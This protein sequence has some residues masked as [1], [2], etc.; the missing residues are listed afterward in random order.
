MQNFDFE[1]EFLSGRSLLLR[2]RSERFFA[3]GSCIQKEE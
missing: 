1:Q 2:V 3:P